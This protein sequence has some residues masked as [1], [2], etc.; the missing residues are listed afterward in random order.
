MHVCACNIYI[1]IIF[2]IISVAAVAQCMRQLEPLVLV[3]SNAN[4]ITGLGIKSNINY[5]G[6]EMAPLFS[7][8]QEERLNT[9][10][11]KLETAIESNQIGD[12]TTSAVM[13]LYEYKVK[14]AFVPAS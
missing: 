4:T 5:N 12:I 3:Q 11:S 1:Y 14:F 6:N 7:F 2:L 9:F 8:G 10:I 13:E